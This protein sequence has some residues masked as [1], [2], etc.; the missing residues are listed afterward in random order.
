MLVQS[1]L[2][3]SSPTVELESWGEER[4]EISLQEM[5]HRFHFLAVSYGLIFKTIKLKIS[6]R[7]LT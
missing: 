1:C 2:P 4:G 6:H 7:H 3:A 5:F